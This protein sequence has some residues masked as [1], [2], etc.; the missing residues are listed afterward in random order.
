MRVTYATAYMYHICMP[1]NVPFFIPKSQLLHIRRQKLKHIQISHLTAQMY[2]YFILHSFTR[3]LVEKRTLQNTSE[4]QDERDGGIYI[5]VLV[6]VI[7][8]FLCLL[9]CCCCDD[10]R[11]SRIRERMEEDFLE[12][13]AELDAAQIEV[14]QNQRESLEKKRRK[15]ILKNIVKKASFI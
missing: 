5:G 7:F 9:I 8:S 14:T 2:Q 12:V 11:Q 4:T 6:T 15:Y 10:C 3:K 13:L 1:L